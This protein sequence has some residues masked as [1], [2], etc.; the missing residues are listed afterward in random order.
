MACSRIPKAASTGASGAAAAASPHKPCPPAMPEKGRGAHP[1]SFCCA[2]A[3]THGC[4]ACILMRSGTSC[5]AAPCVWQSS[6][7]TAAERTVCWGRTSPPEK[8]LCMSCPAAAGSAPC[9]VRGPPYALVGC[10]VAP[11]FDFA[12]FELAPDADSIRHSL[13]HC[14]AAASRILDD[15]FLSPTPAGA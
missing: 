15:F 12:D 11:G 3:S 4:I 8:R 10:T 7:L 14:D 13:P 1:S 6:I 5:W 9:P 2:P